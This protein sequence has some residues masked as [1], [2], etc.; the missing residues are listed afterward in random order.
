MI[1]DRISDI[2]IDMVCNI[3]YNRELV[4]KH[5]LY[6]YT[7]TDASIITFDHSWDSIT[8]L[9]NDMQCYLGED[10]D[11]IAIGLIRMIY[12]T[13]IDGRDIIDNGIGNNNNFCFFTLD[14][15]ESIYTSAEIYNF[16]KDYKDE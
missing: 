6:G 3:H 4:P 11:D 10:C 13:N 15:K 8:D 2:N 7:I 14:D 5:L 1:K 9:S 16:I 12:V